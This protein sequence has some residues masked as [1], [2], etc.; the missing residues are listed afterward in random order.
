M[1]RYLA[2]LVYGWV[3]CGSPITGWFITLLNDKLIPLVF[4]C[5]CTIVDMDFDG[6][7]VCY[8]YVPI[9]LVRCTFYG[10]NYVWLSTCFYQY[11]NGYFIYDLISDKA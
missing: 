6:R 2:H 5:K 4:I 11:L 10:S 7:Y 3:E 1:K 8:I 9:M